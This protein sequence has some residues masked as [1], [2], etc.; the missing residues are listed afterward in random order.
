MDI[1]K[2]TSYCPVQV[3]NMILLFELFDG[4][5]FIFNI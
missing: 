1:P 2:C 4:E 5:K 3:D